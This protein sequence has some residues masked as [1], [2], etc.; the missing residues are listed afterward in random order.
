M[1][2]TLRPGGAERSLAA[3]APQYRDLGIALDVAVLVETDGLQDEIRAAGAALFCVGAGRRLG[4]VRRFADLVR[5]RRPDL[6]HTTLFE[7]D[8]VGRT[9]A[10]VA[11]TRVVSSLVNEALRADHAAEPGIRSSRLR[12][13]QALDALT[14]RAT[15]R[16]HAVSNRVAEIM[17]RRLVYPRDRIDVI[18][19]A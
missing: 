19:R 15:I 6:V 3:L 4:Q 14:A 5:Y 17:S 12:A 9:G 10:R 16:M 8:I 11:G 13:A 2:D 18:P 7:S 1:I